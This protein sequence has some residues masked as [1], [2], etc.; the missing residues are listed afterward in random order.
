MMCSHVGDL[1]NFFADSNG[2]A[3]VTFTDSVI[4]LMGLQSIIGRTIVVCICD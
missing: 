2:N 1:G 3:R 4:T